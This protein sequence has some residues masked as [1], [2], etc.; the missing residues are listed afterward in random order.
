MKTLIL[1]LF[2]TQTITHASS[3]AYGALERLSPSD[4]PYFSSG[5]AEGKYLVPG[6][7]VSTRESY[8]VPQRTDTLPI[9]E[10]NFRPATI[11]NKEN[12]TTADLP[13]GMIK[14]SALVVG[15]FFALFLHRRTRKA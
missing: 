10:G 1:V 4:S 5:E 9:Y 6:T 2:L 14:F 7:D 11:T 3:F 15:G 12:W 13:A 8:R